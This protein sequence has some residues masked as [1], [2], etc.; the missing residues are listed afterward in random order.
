MKVYGYHGILPCENENGQFFYFDIEMYLDLKKAGNSD[1]IE[2][3]VNYSKVYDL[4]TFIVG[5]E[6]FKLIEKLAATIARSILEEY[7]IIDRVKIL[8]K[9]PNAPIKG[10]FDWV[11]VKVNMK[12]S[13]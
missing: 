11:G 3:T 12:R 8:V 4:V 10:E 9:K 2:D 6:K 5:K 13:D 7:A 1:N